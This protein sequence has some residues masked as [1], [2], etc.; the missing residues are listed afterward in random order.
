MSKKN[1]TMEDVFREVIKIRNQPD[2]YPKPQPKKKPKKDEPC[3]S[4]Q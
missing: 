3:D 1:P 4:C 2:K